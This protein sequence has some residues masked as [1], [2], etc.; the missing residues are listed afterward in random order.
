MRHYS[1][2]YMV[3]PVGV[4]FGLNWCSHAC[5]YCFA[6][7][8]Q[9]QRRADFSQAMN[10]IRKAAGNAET[11][12]IAA[13]LLRA[14]HRILSAN[15]SDPF[16]VSN[17]DAFQQ[18]Y[19]FARER[20]F[21][22][23]FQTRGG[24]HAIRTIEGHPPTFVYVSL[25]GDD[26]A[27]VKAA[28][29]GAP[30]LGARYELIAAAKAA[31]HNVVVGLNPFRP[32]WWRDLDGLLLKLLELGVRHVWGGEL[33]MNRFQKTAMQAKR[34]ER[35]AEE[36]EY[37]MARHKGDRLEAQAFFARLL[38]AGINVFEG[39]FS[40][41]GGFWDEYEAMAGVVSPTMESLFGRLRREGSGKPVVM[42][43]D[44]FDAWANRLPDARASAFKEYCSGF[45]RSLRNM[46]E[47][48]K[49]NSFREVHE[50]F[51]RVL[52]VPTVFDDDH[53]AI[54]VEGPDPDEPM[55]TDE[56]DRPLL[57]WSPEPHDKPF[58]PADQ[59]DD[60]M[61]FLMDP[62]SAKAS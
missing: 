37:A 60:G 9:P 57:V 49:A 55:L 3:S 24:E 43:L 62:A 52:E 48:T 50:A 29:P 16:A 46:G 34:R 14:G 51:W 7:L 22:F 27:A 35:H 32:S 15:D 21:L 41:L 6:N 8:N 23:A 56:A 20:G 11:K 58:M 25:T 2:E 44:W 59:G 33:H 1:G 36:I 45:G 26:D 53:F 5:W 61:V 40:D 30:L 31:G 28:E 17:S 18:V 19:E 13:N 38:D 47:D 10:T 4:H 39:S 54:A 42:S 12:D